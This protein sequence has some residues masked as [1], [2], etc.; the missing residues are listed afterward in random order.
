MK[1]IA[2]E[3]SSY[4]TF[5]EQEDIDRLEQRYACIY[6]QMIS[7][8]ERLD[9]KDKLSINER[10]LMHAILEY[11]ADIK[12]VKVAHNLNH[13]NGQKVMAYLAYWLLRRQPIQI[14]SANDKDENI[15]FANEKFVLTML[16]GFLMHG[17]EAKSLV[18]D[19]LKVYKAFLNSL[20]YYLKFRKPDAQSIE[21]ALL[22]FD[23]GKIFSK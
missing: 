2:S 13:T 7:F 20:F 6:E 21:M 5:K 9:A 15:I 3:Y 19:D 1:Y 16:M 12:K 14:L 18:G 22:A 4:E 10:V 17:S 23:C 11:Y 8:I